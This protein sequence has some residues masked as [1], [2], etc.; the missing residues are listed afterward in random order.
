MFLNKAGCKEIRRNGGHI[1]FSKKEL[2]RPIVV[3]SH[4]DPVPEFIIKNALRALGLTKKDF[5]EILFN[6]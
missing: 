2:T 5:F 4:I 1:I 6:Q 3:Q